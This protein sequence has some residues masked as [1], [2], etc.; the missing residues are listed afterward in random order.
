M[1]K[2]L[3][4]F[5]FTLMLAGLLYTSISASEFQEELTL[6]DR[7]FF[8][9][10]FGLQLGTVTNVEVSPIIGYKVTPR[11]SGGIGIRYEYYKDSR[12]IPGYIPF[13]TNILGGSLFSRYILIQNIEE[14]IGLGLNASILVQAEYEVLSLEKQY[15]EVPS[16]LDE[17]RFPLHSI[18]LGGGLYQPVGRRSGLVLMVLWNLTQTASSPYS[19]PIIRL[20]FNF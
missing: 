16:T 4:T 17:G 6:K 18:L 19:N 5:S 12:N 8:G 20:G 11:F 1:R 9:G 2:F 14:V 15:F 13:E 10:N 3:Y 7:L